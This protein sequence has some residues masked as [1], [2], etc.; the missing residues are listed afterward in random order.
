MNYH[1]RV[2]IYFR[3]LIA[4][5]Y[6]RWQGIF[7]ELLQDWESVRN[8]LKTTAT[9]SLIKTYNQPTFSARSIALDSTFKDSFFRIDICRL[10]LTIL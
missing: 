4:N 1:G 7:K 8:F 5:S 9:L 6:T 3:I 10:E 2:E